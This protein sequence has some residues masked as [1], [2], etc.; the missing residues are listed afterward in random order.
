LPND[1]DTLGAMKMPFKPDPKK[2]Y[3]STREAADLFGCTMGRIRQLALAGDLWCGH[4]HDRALVYDM[5]EV[6]RKAK[7]KPTTGRP[8][9][10]R[11]S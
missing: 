4:L 5:D 2:T 8:R 7:E 3:I 9:K 1:V 10:R 6:K 11:A